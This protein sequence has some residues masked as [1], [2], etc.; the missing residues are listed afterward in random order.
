M[1]QDIKQRIKNSFKGELEIF[2]SNK[3]MIAGGL[4]TSVFSGKEVNDVD[5]YFRSREDF[6][7][8]L[9]DLEDE[10]GIYI[11]SITDK[12]LTL[13]GLCGATVQLIYTGFYETPQDIFNDFDWTVNMCAYDFETD[14]I[15]HDENFLT[16]LATR[17][18]RFNKG[19]A[20]PLISAI[21]IQKYVNKGYNITLSETRRVLLE[22][23]KLDISTREE[24]V[25][26]VGGMYGSAALRL[27]DDTEEF[28][29]DRAMDKLTEALNTSTPTIWNDYVEID[30]PISLT[31]GNVVEAIDAMEHE[32]FTFYVRGETAYDSSHDSLGSAIAFRTLLR[33]K[34][35]ES[36]QCIS[37][38]VYYKWVKEID[39]QLV[40]W[41]DKDFKYNVGEEARDDKHG[42]YILS[43]D[44]ALQNTS[45][46]RDGTHLI[47]CQVE[48]SDFIDFDGGHG[49]DKI[50]V[51]KFKVL[52]SWAKEDIN[53]N[54]LMP[55]PKPSS[56]LNKA[57]ET[58]KP[59]FARI[60]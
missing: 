23:A 50:R 12:S 41:Y 40:S 11:T 35:V 32:D 60:K 36:P 28:D 29:L 42:V 8:M 6:H 34:E 43:S 18:L 14:E 5:C 13:T 51:R 19:T 4:L 16:D 21:R 2:K 20:F 26:H 33:D 44:L 56:N 54:T 46:R 45:Y 15:V 48:S 9:K 55:S 17:K 57:A 24:F 3:V 38:G 53:E 25:K 7:N 39:G 58:P 31:I 22:V 30:K 52:H 37:S 27:L 1:Y 49:S 10:G 59:L 47:A